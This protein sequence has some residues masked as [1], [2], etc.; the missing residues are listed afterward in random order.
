MTNSKQHCDVCG[1]RW[2]FA[3]SNCRPE[4][5]RFPKRRLFDAAGNRLSTV[6]IQSDGS[7]FEI[8][9]L[10]MKTFPTEAEWKLAYPTGTEV[11]AD[12][13]KIDAT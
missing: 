9:P 4:I 10:T 1:V 2:S 8:S 13:I 7:L 11:K 6:R 5:P 3:H 12:A